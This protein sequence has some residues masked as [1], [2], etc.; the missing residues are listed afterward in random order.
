MIEEGIR[1]IVT[2][3]DGVYIT[4]KVIKNNEF[5]GVTIL[6]MSDL[7]EPTKVVLPTDSILSIVEES[8]SQREVLESILSEKEL[9]TI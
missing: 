3:N 2:T 8:Y 1:F 4:P 7:S 6:D 5:D 9:I